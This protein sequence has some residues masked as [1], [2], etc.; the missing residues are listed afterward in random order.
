[1]TRQCLSEAGTKVSGRK[2]V[3]GGAADSLLL[4]LLLLVLVALALSVGSQMDAVAALHTAQSGEEADALRLA[5]AR[6]E[7]LRGLGVEEAGALAGVSY[8]RVDAMGPQYRVATSVDTGSEVPAGCVIV[9]WGEPAHSL[10][11][12]TVLGVGHEGGP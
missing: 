12:Q 9:T 8:E 2:R 11:L 1:M 10:C 3:S 5:S 7:T 4:V 6:L